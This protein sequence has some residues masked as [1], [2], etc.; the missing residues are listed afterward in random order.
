MTKKSKVRLNP[1]AGVGVSILPGLRLWIS[2]GKNG[3]RINVYSD[4]ARVLQSLERRLLN[5]KSEG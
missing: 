1:R 4:P 5:G 3:P 2:I